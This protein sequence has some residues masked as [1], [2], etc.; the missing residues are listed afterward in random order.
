MA[1]CSWCYEGMD[2]Q[3]DPSSCLL[4]QGYAGDLVRSRLGLLE[5]AA[6]ALDG[7]RDPRCLLAGFSIIQQLA[8]LYRKSGDAPAKVSTFA[9]ACKCSACAIWRGSYTQEL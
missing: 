3:P 4:C 6:A 2:S 5:G 8:G 7:E 1:S 9:S